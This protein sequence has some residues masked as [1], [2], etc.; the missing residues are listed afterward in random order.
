MLGLAY[1]SLFRKMGAGAGAFD[2][3]PPQPCLDMSGWTAPSFSVVLLLPAARTEPVLLRKYNTV[4]ALAVRAGAALDCPAEELNFVTD[5]TLLCNWSATLADCN[6]MDG[7]L[8][9]VVRSVAL[10]LPFA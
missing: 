7:D 4:E 9:T 3:P 5:L 8:V 10:F 6:L 2:A 1:F